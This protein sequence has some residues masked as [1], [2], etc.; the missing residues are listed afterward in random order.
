MSNPAS[1]LIRQTKAEDASNL[2]WTPEETD[3]FSWPPERYPIHGTSK[4][5]DAATRYARKRILGQSRKD[6]HLFV[7]VVSPDGSSLR[8][9]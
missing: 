7:S 8:V 2:R 1:R 5:E 4:T 6:F 3:T 9:W